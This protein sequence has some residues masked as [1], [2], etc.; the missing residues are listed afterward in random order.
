MS[1]QKTCIVKENFLQERMLM[2]W[3]VAMYRDRQLFFLVRN[4]N[5]SVENQSRHAN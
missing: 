3:L 5:E 2:K 1:K 4:E